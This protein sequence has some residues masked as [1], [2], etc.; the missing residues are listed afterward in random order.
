MTDAPRQIAIVTD[1]D[2]LVAAFRAR[3]NEL[4]VSRA[5]LDDVS[6]LASGYASKLLATPPIKTVGAVSLGP[7]LGA[8]GM[9]IVL[10]EDPEQLRRIASRMVDRNTAQVRGHANAS[11]PSPKWLFNSKK[12][13]KA[14]TKRWENATPA[15][16]KRIARK[17]WRTRRRR[18]KL[19]T[20]K[21]SR[22]SSTETACVGPIAPSLDRDVHTRISTRSP[23]AGA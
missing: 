16:R 2:S 20:S 17:A 4:N 19:A 18:A 12:A 8:L 13:R 15:Q 21:D 14:A 22:T 5:T 3:A 9:S 6:G 11:S 7:I 1:Y 10:V 23:L